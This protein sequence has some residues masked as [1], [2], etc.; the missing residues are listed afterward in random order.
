MYL[1][2]HLYLFFSLIQKGARDYL[3]LYLYLYL[4]FSLILRGEEGVFYARLCPHIAGS[5]PKTLMDSIS[6]DMEIYLKQKKREKPTI[7][8]SYI[9][10][11]IF[12]KKEKEK[13]KVS[14]L[15]HE[16]ALILHNQHQ[17]VMA[18]NISFDIYQLN[19]LMSF[20]VC[21]KRTGNKPLHISQRL[22]FSKSGISVKKKGW[23]ILFEL[24][25]WDVTDIWGAHTR[26]CTYI[27][28][29]SD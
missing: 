10:K 11:N 2:L 24:G 9:L 4:L 25:N 22:V 28:Q 12:F 19:A 29:S 16:C 3:Y 7:C 17:W 15:V 1:N 23:R 21:Q 13:K 18:S 5:T 14:I 20:I 27:N 8:R 6:F 26:W